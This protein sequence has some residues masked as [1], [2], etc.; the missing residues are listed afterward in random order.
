MR[1]SC[2]I[3]VLYRPRN[4]KGTVALPTKYEHVV[5]VQTFFLSFFRVCVGVLYVYESVHIVSQARCDMH[6]CII[7]EADVNYSSL[8]EGEKNMQLFLS[9][10]T[11]Q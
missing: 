2:L 10:G 3:V 8:C 7:C 9:I 6:L 1:S 11:D 4:K 5:T